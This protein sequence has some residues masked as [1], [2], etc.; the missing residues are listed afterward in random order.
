MEAELSDVGILI[1]YLLQQ[2]AWLVS[3]LGCWGGGDT[4]R[5][6]LLEVLPCLF[7]QGQILEVF[8]EVVLLLLCHLKTVRH[9]ERVENAIGI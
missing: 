8:L 2:C 3:L 1:L 7:S 9:K 5:N 4:Q 6:F